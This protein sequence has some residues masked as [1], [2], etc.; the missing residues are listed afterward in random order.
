MNLTTKELRKIILESLEND[1]TS[2]MELKMR[3][4]SEDMQS[5]LAEMKNLHAEMCSPETS[6]ISKSYYAKR[7]GNIYEKIKKSSSKLMKIAKEN[8]ALYEEAKRSSAE[9]L[10]DSS[11]QETT[12]SFL[13]E[14]IKELSEQS[15]KEFILEISDI[16]EEI[17]PG[18]RSKINEDFGVAEI[19]LENIAKEIK[20]TR[21]KLMS[22]TSEQREKILKMA[23]E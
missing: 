15:R 6:R 10:E 20:R 17:S 14:F 19:K 2:T 12:A 13:L 21:N 8:L 16:M 22:L 11:P 5:T 23:E 1:P 18:T 9:L 4:R 7:V 3:W